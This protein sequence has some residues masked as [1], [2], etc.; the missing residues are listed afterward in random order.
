M[1][2]DRKDRG[3]FYIQPDYWEAVEDM[4]SAQ[5]DKFFGAIVRLFFTGEPQDP[6]QPVKGAYVNARA[7]VLSARNKSRH[8]RDDNHENTVNDTTKTP[9]ENREPSI[10]GEGDSYISSSSGRVSSPD[11]Q[12]VSIPQVDTGS[13]GSSKFVADALLIFSEVTGRA[14]LMPSGAVT[15]YLMR[16]YDAGYNLDDIRAVC[17]YKFAEWHDDPRN[18]G[19]IRPSTLFEPSKFEGY[20]A[21]AKNDPG[22]S[23]DAEAAEFAAAF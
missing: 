18:Q 16:I 1:A 13:D 21:A 9:R 2:D 11:I 3:G 8:N 17:S 4:T 19:Y 6:K 23:I 14:C 7:R 5:Q 20:L 22:V 15:G 12:P 10:E